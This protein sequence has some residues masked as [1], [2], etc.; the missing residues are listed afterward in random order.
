MVGPLLVAVVQPVD[1]GEQHPQ[2]ETRREEGNLPPGSDP[3]WRRLGRREFHRDDVRNEKTDDVGDQQETPHEPTAAPPA[4]GHESAAS[5]AIASPCDTAI[6][7]CG[8]A[9]TQSSPNSAARSLAGGP[10]PLAPTEYSRY[11]AIHRAKLRTALD[12]YKSTRTQDP[13]VA[14]FNA[15]HQPPSECVCFGDVQCECGPLGGSRRLLDCSSS[16]QPRSRTLGRLRA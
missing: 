2:R 15:R 13:E 14:P 5:I 16:H 11:L 7:S 9:L 6:A 8:T 12:R 4:D 10:V 1:P 3:I